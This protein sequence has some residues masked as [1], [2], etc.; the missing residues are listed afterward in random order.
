MSLPKKAVLVGINYFSIPGITLHGCINDVVN[1]SHTLADAFDY[2]INNITIL[3]DDTQ[4]A[5]LSP[6]RNNILTQL[7]NVVNQSANLSEI[8]FHY[9][10][11]GSQI[12]DLNGDEVDG[13]DEVIVPVD[14]QRNGFIVDDEIFNII[15]NVKCRMI[16]IFDSCHSGSIC[17]LKWGFEYNNGTIIKSIN[18]GKLAT[19]PNIFVFSGCKDTQT[20]ADAYST[21]AQLAVGAF[22]DC[23]LHCLRLNHMNVDIMKLYSDVCNYIKSNGFTQTPTLTSSSETPS[24]TFVRATSSPVANTNTK[25]VVTSSS[26]SSSSSSSVLSNTLKDIVF[27]ESSN[28]IPPVVYSDFLLNSF[29]S[30]RIKPPMGKLLFL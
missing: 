30:N 25:S 22:T 12:R 6:T 15:K 19:N 14:Y 5:N 13:L 26:S 10:G 2:D 20:S 29:S 9:S 28:M 1:M 4:N 3:R 16:M 17:D 11:H 18:S 27:N 8:W 21:E 24:Y 7:V 23:F